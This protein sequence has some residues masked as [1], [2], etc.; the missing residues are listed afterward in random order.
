MKSITRI[1]LIAAGIAL[2][3]TLANADWQGNS[4]NKWLNTRDNH[5]QHAVRDALLDPAVLVAKERVLLFLEN[6]ERAA[7]DDARRD[8]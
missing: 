5:Q 8:R 6:A 1:V 2:A 4:Y 7:I 3:P